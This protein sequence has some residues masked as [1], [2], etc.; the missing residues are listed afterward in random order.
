M[1]VLIA[2]EVEVQVQGRSRVTIWGK[3]RKHN[4][5]QEARVA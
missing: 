5:T 2:A 4:Y 3:E 1:L